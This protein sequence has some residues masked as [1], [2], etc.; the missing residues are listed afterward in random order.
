MGVLACAHFS[1]KKLRNVEGKLVVCSNELKA[2][3]SL[4]EGLFL[5]FYLYFCA[6]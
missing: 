3:V 2:N 6:V 1:C 5:G 4:K